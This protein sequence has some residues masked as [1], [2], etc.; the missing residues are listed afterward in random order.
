MHKAWTTARE[1]E[2]SG[3]A[4][5]RGRGHSAD[6]RARRRL[7]ERGVVVCVC[8]ASG[9]AIVHSR[10]GDAASDDAALSDWLALSRAAVVYAIEMRCKGILSAECHAMSAPGDGLRLSSFLETATAAKVTPLRDGA[11]EGSAP[12]VLAVKRVPAHQNAT[13]EPKDVVQG[14]PDH[15]AARRVRADG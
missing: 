5:G 9:G 2:R 1:R 3:A 6:P 7:R 8:A 10:R 13:G 12:P 14:A 4:G 15:G 11:A